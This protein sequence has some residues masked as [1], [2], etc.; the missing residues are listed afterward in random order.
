MISGE[1]YNCGVGEDSPMWFRPSPAGM[2]ACAP[3]Q[4]TLPDF[5]LAATKKLEGGRKETRKKREM[6][7][8]LART[9][10]E[11]SAKPARNEREKWSLN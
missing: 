7:A 3:K 5:D 6:C 1:E 9:Y 10:R 2:P 11:T 8:P 4:L